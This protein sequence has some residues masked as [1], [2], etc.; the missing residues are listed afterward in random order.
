MNTGDGDEAFAMQLTVVR[1]LLEIWAG[2]VP[3]EKEDV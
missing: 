1:P 3:H 2:Q